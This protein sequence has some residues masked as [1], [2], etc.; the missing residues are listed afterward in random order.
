[1]ATNDPET[2]TGA[3]KAAVVL[4]AIGEDLATKVLAKMPEADRDQIM[5]EYMR[6]QRLPSE[7]ISKILEE[8]AG[9][10]EHGAYAFSG[11][12]DE[13]ERILTALIGKDDAKKALDRYEQQIQ[14]APF[15]F[16]QEYD[17]KNV[18]LALEEEYP[19]S[20]AV[21]L[22]YLEPKNAMAILAAFTDRRKAAEVAMRI[23]K[24]RGVRDT[25]AVDALQ[26]YLRLRLRGA[27]RGTYASEFD[28]KT[29][30]VDMVTKG[31]QKALEDVILADLK[32]YDE[33]LYTEVQKNMF[34][35]EGLKDLRAEDLAKLVAKVSA[36]LPLVD[37]GL[38]LRT[39]DREISETIIGQLTKDN[40]EIVREYLG[41]KKYRASQIEEAR[42]KIIAIALDMA[43]DGDITLS[44]VEQQEDAD[45]YV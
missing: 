21:V 33:P 13:T 8:A 27:V 2:L 42:A 24:L 32:S 28:G 6:N 15:V 34:K 3:K 41:A 11:G 31:G 29:H 40:A 26:A 4:M 35:W 36:S 16:L 23:G 1:M 19:Q 14:D 7:Q 22:S 30:L 37:L 45:T 43:E 44:L 12:R 25:S 39:S 18:A 10:V 20:I 5:V 38:A 17:A 9:V